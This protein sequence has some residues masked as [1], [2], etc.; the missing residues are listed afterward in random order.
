MQLDVLDGIA[1]VAAIVVVVLALLFI[2][3]IWMAA[4]GHPIF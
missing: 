4:L 1:I 3:F 2:T